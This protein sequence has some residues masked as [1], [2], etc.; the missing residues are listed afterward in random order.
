MKCKIIRVYIPFKLVPSYSW[1]KFR[2]G[3]A[4]SCSSMPGEI[5]QMKKDK[6]QMISNKKQDKFINTESRLMATRRK[7]W[8]VSGGLSG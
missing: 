4:G 6:N 5:S 3:R 1:G 7:G 2:K 8:L